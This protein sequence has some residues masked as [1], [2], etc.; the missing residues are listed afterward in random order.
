MS[1]E[2]K[3]NNLTEENERLRKEQAELRNVIAQM[4]ITLNRLMN[5]YITNTERFPEK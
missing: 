2:E 3:L 4:K 1:I 5:R